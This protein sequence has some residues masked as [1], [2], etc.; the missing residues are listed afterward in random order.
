MVTV[1]G[2][3]VGAG[4]P[5]TVGKGE[6]VKSGWRCKRRCNDY[7]DNNNMRHFLRDLLCHQEGGQL[8]HLNGLN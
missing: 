2:C 6:G 8:C 5:E 1:G 3:E 4:E 7:G